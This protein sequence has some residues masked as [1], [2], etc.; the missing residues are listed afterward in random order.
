MQEDKEVKKLVNRIF[1]MKGLPKVINFAQEFA[2]GSK[3]FLI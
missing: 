3:Y 2:D 1:K